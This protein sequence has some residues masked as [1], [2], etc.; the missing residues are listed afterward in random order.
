MPRRSPVGELA[1][2]QT[3]KEFADRLSSYTALTAEEI[4]RLFPA[5]TDRDELLELI[6]IVDADADDKEKRAELIAKIGGI[7]RAVLAITKKFAGIP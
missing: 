1:S 2:A 4:E 7:S 6:R 3:K 5:K